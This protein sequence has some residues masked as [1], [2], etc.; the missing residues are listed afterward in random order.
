MDSLS[1]YV[2]VIITTFAIDLG[3]RLSPSRSGPASHKSLS[4]IALLI[5]CLCEKPRAYDNKAH[6]VK[7]FSLA[8]FVTV[9]LLFAAIELARLGIPADPTILDFSLILGPVFIVPFA[10]FLFGLISVKPLTL[11]RLLLEFR[12]R[13]ALALILSANIIFVV[14]E[15]IQHIAYVLVHF[16]LASSALVGI[17]FLNSEQRTINSAFHAPLK[18]TDSDLLPG[19]AYYLMSIEE[20]LYYFLLTAW[21][22]LTAPIQSLISSPLGLTWI[23]II[24]GILIAAANLVIRLRLIFSSSRLLSIYEERALPLSFLLFGLISIVRYYL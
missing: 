9:S 8:I 15:P 10:H 1:A 5:L 24:L 13:G 3:L 18:K 16:F 22:F 14:L 4:L 12:L 7:Q 20:L 19:F 2:L 6:V 21:V 17:F 23:L 11:S